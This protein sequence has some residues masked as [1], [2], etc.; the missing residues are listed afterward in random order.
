MSDN[1]YGQQWSSGASP[2]T[3]DGSNW[4]QSPQSGWV[5]VT[6]D[7]DSEA[8]GDGSRPDEWTDWLQGR[9]VRK[10]GRAPEVCIRM[11]DPALSALLLENGFRRI[12]T[13]PE[14]WVHPDTGDEFYLLREAES[15]PVDGTDPGGAVAAP[16]DP[17][18]TNAADWAAYLTGERDRLSAQAAQLANGS[19]AAGYKELY[20]QF[21]DAWNGWSSQ[22][23]ATKSLF[24]TWDNAVTD[25]GQLCLEHH[26]DQILWLIEDRSSD[27]VELNSRLPTPAD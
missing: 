19:D 10:G 8:P 6:D 17:V 23:D 26:R 24:A 11:Y 27:L 1:S 18:C 9:W 14:H 16:E 21:W 20:L 4:E 5:D 25:Q 15:V 3:S 13:A 22:L 7:M 2:S 12:H